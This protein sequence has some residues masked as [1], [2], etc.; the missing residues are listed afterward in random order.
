MIKEYLLKFRQLDIYDKLIIS[1]GVIFALGNPW[2]HFF[3]YLG[4]GIGFLAA[5]FK[6]RS[7]SNIKAE[8]TLLYF[9]A[10][11]LIWAFILNIF[12]ADEKLHSFNVVMAYFSHW[13]VP[14]IAG[15]FITRIFRI[16]LTLGWIV[17][18]F[19]I[20][21]I[22]IFA[23]L[24]LFEAPQFAREGMIWGRHHHIQIAALFTICFHIVYG[25]ILTPVLSRR[26]T[27]ILSIAALILII[28]IALTGSRG[29]WLAAGLSAIGATVHNFILNRRRLLTIGISA[30]GIII[31][32]VSFLTVPQVQ[33]RLNMTSFE[34]DNYIYR[35]N[36]SIMALKIIG[37]HPIAGI[38]PGQ[39]KYAKDYYQKMEDLNLPVETGYMKK[40]HL[41][42][43]Y[44]HIGAEFGIIGMILIIGILFGFF[45]MLVKI[46]KISSESINSG[47]ILG[48][49]WA[50]AGI[51]I[52]DILDCLFRGPS[53]A[54]D[55][56][57][58]GGLAAGYLRDGSN[59][60]IV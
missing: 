25:M 60:N 48:L 2:G 7:L 37:D 43:F 59:D 53:V 44:L 33:H 4:S 1:G 46:Y 47:L 54:M 34:D 24:G 13:L 38:G 29:Y 14:F 49:I 23:F 11:F 9:M 50:L 26:K 36:M 22:S 8:K 57:W 41:H 21:I 3:G 52:G 45:F 27:I 12:V 35:K 31:I 30:V 16:P 6:L 58:L 39:V 15:Y 55:I 5:L 32:A 42:N 28:F 20:G 40:N 10:A 51:C 18:F 19:I 17:T 56:F